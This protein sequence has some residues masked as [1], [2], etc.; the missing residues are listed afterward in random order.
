MYDLDIL[1]LQQY[2]KNE[3]KNIKIKK[4]ICK[5]FIERHPAVY[6]EASDYKKSETEIHDGVE[7]KKLAN[8]H[9]VL[10]ESF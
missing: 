7:G 1:W 10:I 4:K 3:Q 6:R 9:P 8:V 5:Y 2:D